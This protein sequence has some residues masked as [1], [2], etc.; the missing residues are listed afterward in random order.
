[1]VLVSKSFMYL[2]NS[3]YFLSPTTQFRSRQAIIV[4]FFFGFQNFILDM[5]FGFWYD[6]VYACLLWLTLL[7]PCLNY[8]EMV[9]VVGNEAVVWQWKIKQYVNL[10]LSLLLLSP[11]PLAVALGF[12]AMDLDLRRLRFFTFFL[13]L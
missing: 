13:F 5:V 9:V 12:S 7:L 3:F 2:L 11:P 1:M 4:L 10:Q 8:R 6:L